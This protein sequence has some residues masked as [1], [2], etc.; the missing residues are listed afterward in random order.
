MEKR[1]IVRKIDESG[2]PVRDACRAFGVSHSSYYRWRMGGRKKERGPSWNALS[3]DERSRI[4]SEAASHPEQPP[5]QIA[6]K[7]TDEGGFSVSKSTVH[8]VLKKAGKIADRK[9]ERVSAAKEYSYKPRSVHEQWQTDFTDFFVPRWGR[10]H[11][12][13]VL[14]D[15]SRFMLHHDLRPYEKSAD[16][17]EVIDG[18]VE[19][20]R[21]THGY[22]ARRIVS[23]KGK[24][25]EAAD[26]KNYLGLVNIR[27]IHARAR[28]PQTVGKLERLHRTMK[29]MV[30]VHVYDNPWDLSRAIDEFYRYYNY[31]R[32]HESLGDV[33]PADVYFG[34]A[35][36]VL[37]RRREI[38]ARTMKERRRRYEA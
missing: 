10:Y 35:E 13:G 7:L 34:R 3:S 22:A 24:C 19:F 17:V 9:V 23:D 36:E 12:G 1:K 33:T 37:A 28:H 8:R 38:K 14:D 32:Y 26:T 30:N 18:A 27:P 31:E 11:D 29:E 25:F 16:A 5:R 2:L 6:L 21:L 15:R 20:A 4:L